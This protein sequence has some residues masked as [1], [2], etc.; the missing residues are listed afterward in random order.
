[1]VSVRLARICCVPTHRPCC[2]F[3]P[4]IPSLPRPP[5]A[6]PCNLIFDLPNPPFIGSRPA[7][8]PP[9]PPRQAHELV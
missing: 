5:P 4:H 8:S 3:H 7:R 2:P 6:L 9:V 1:V